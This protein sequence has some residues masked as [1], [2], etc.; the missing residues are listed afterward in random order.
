MKKTTAKGQLLPRSTSRR[1]L[2][3]LA[4]AMGA[5]AAGAAVFAAP[6][7]AAAV[8]G[9]D[10]TSTAVGGTN[11]GTSQTNGPVKGK[12]KKVKVKGQVVVGAPGT[13]G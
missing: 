11:T 1:G 12:N 7:D 10:A 8:D 3:R 13:P 5:G 6:R 2:L 4:A 9:E